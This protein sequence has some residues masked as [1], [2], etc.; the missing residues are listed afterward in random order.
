MTVQKLTIQVGSA[1]TRTVS[2]NVSGTFF[3]VGLP[4][5]LSISSAG[6]IS[7][8]PTTPGIYTSTVFCVARKDVG[9]AVLDYTVIAVPVPVIT[10]S[11]DQT[12]ETGVSTTYQVT[13]TSALPIL[14]YAASN[15]FSGLSI[16]P[17][18]GLISGTPSTSVS[19]TPLIR[20]ISRLSAI[21]SAGTGERDVLFRF[22]QRPVITS[23]L[24]PIILDHG[25][26][27]TPYTITASKTPTSYAATPLPTGLSVSTS[28]G[29]VSGTPSGF[30]QTT[31]TLSAFNGQL[32]G[33]ATLNFTVNKLLEI[34]SG[35]ASGQETI[36]F[37]YQIT[38]ANGFPST[39]LSYGAT[40][41][42]SGVTLNT[43][44]GL[45]SGTPIVF[46]TF[47]VTLSVTTSY[48]TTTKSINFVIAQAPGL[49]NTPR[50]VA[51]SATY[52]LIFADEQNNAVRTIS[53]PFSS[54]RVLGTLATGIT[55]PYG[56]VETYNGKIYASS[57]STGNVFRWNGTSWVTAASGLTTPRS[58]CC[59]TSNSVYVAAGTS[60]VKI[61]D[62]GVVSTFATSAVE[63][64][65]VNVFNFS[66]ATSYLI[67][68][69]YTFTG[70]GSFPY[71]TRVYF[72]TTAGSIGTT[73]SN[74]S[75]APTPLGLGGTT[76]WS[77]SP[78][79]Y[80][81]AQTSTN[82]AS[83][84]S[85]FSSTS[86]SNFVSTLGQPVGSPFISNGWYSS[87]SSGSINLITFFNYVSG[88][89]VSVVA[90]SPSPGLRDGPV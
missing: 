17:T 90:S 44:T 26:A 52:G 35:N 16:D 62:A 1:H 8:T 78:L 30:G 3:A 61:T 43:T 31:T 32:T 4:P 75:S 6:V 60:L 36:A 82:S 5:G 83:L 12:R 25:V 73:L 37:S 22:Q 89:Q 20:H 63:L 69:G 11:D 9:V 45:I 79:S 57:P 38:T 76:T 66:G 21:S 28:T 84:V 72:I 15:L 58:L 74:S 7:G 81:F 18:T 85:N 49:F 2:S 68:G 29:I 56:V 14:S 64:W 47:P 80:G 50:Q 48:G 24:T 33:T 19:E 39:V 55:A 46:G 27:I 53:N 87:F 77:T 13:A 67:A 70:V 88:I 42:P 71:D 65:A 34:T 51:P 10:S 86:S 23:S 59:D 40:G 54:P 41:L